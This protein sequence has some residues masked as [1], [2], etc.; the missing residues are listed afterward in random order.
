[1]AT[2]NN[3]EYIFDISQ[4]TPEDALENILGLEVPTQ[5]ARVIV[6]SRVHADFLAEHELKPDNGICFEGP[7]GVGKS[8]IIRGMTYELARETGQQADLLTLTAARVY[9]SRENP[10]DVIEEVFEQ[11]RTYKG[12]AVFLLSEAEGLFPRST[13]MIS[14]DERRV[15]STAKDLIEALPTENP[16]IIMAATSNDFPGLAAGIVAPQRINRHHHLDRPT[17]SERVKFLN[18]LMKTARYRRHGMVFEQ[19]LN[20]NSILQPDLPFTVGNL[21]E[22]VRRAKELNVLEAAQGQP[23]KRVTA[24]QLETVIHDYRQ[25]IPT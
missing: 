1:M 13:P 4:P 15:T 9:R 20:A 14:G 10:V 18:Q 12:W 21:L 8:T 19:G 5:A 16:R 25:E 2:G 3:S 22:A 7:P 17:H 24:A 6:Q 11:A 23:L